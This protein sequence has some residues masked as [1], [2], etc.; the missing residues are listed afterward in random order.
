MGG[1]VILHM[2]PML[3]TSSMTS[4]KQI[5][6]ISKVQMGPAVILWSYLGQAVSGNIHVKSTT[7][8]HAIVAKFCLD[9][10]H[11]A[12]SKNTSI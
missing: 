11:W 4:Q 10:N 3:M 12:A 1:Y 5:I 6:Y 8:S 9:V 2:D 7:H